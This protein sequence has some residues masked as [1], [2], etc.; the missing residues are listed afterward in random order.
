MIPGRKPK[1]DDRKVTRHPL[2]HDWMDVPE[3]PF[4]GE[5]PVLPR[6]G[7]ATREWWERVSTM[8]HCLLWQPSDWG[9]ALD[10]A[11]LHAAYCRK[12]G[13]R[14]AGELR[15]REKVMGTTLEA[16]R[17]LRIRYVAVVESVADEPGDRV[18]DIQ[19]ERRRR[20]LGAD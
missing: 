15:N 10:T 20:L 13:E 6:V 17:D 1:D 12:G 5:R 11:R 7:A 2:T 8:P 3:V 4:A 14:F 19:A 16:R 18:S 9:F